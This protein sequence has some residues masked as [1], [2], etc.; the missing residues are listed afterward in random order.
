MNPA[1]FRVA[2]LTCMLGASG[3][4]AT[5]SAMAAE[6]YV[7]TGFPYALVGISQP[8]NGSFS[9]RADF[10]T[11]AH[12]NYTGSTSDNDFKGSVS[13]HRAALVGDWFVAGGGFRIT[14]GAT[15]NQA[16]ASMR[17]SAH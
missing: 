12:H 14:G 4:A 16:K 7:A 9:V 3:L 15:F 17:A 6:A 10:A 13:Y 1:S 2:L 8:L 11:I 5:S